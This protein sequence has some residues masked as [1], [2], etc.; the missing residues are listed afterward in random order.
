MNTAEQGNNAK[1]LKGRFTV[2]VLV[3]FIALLA[4]MAATYAW[5]VYNTGRHTTKVRMAAGT[6]INLQISNK[7]DDETAYKSSTMLESFTGKLNPVS[8][9]RI[10]DG[11]RKV[12][13]FTNGKENQPNLVANLF[14]DAEYS[15]KYKDYYKTSLY[16]RSNGESTDVYISDITFEDSSEEAP[17]SSAIRVGFVVHQPGRT[18]AI[19]NE[20]IYAISDAKNPEAEYNT[21]TGEEGYVLDK[22]GNTT[23]DYTLYTKA[24]YCNYDETTGET[25][26]KAKSTKLC[27]VTGGSDGARGTPVQVDV[28]IWL[29]G[30]DEDCTSNLCNQTLQKLAISFAGMVQ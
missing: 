15:D 24:N 9:N 14:G 8:T 7:Y 5:Y 1:Q 22:D 17:I 2:A 21:S 26:L 27:T 10:Q 23:S 3:F 19:Q 30:C 4:A 18:D 25:T 28:Y 16:L 29:E 20:Y 6:G 13:G 12:F 11:F